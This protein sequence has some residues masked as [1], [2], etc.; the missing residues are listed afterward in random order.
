MKKY[1]LTICILVRN[2]ESDVARILSKLLPKKSSEIQV[3]IRDGGS[4]N[5]SKPYIS[6]PLR[7]NAIEYRHIQNEEIDQ[8]IIN[9]IRDAQ[10]EFVW[11]FG[12]DDLAEGALNEVLGLIKKFDK[13]NFIWA[14]FKLLDSNEKAVDLGESRFFIKKKKIFK[15]KKKRKT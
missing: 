10:G 8:K 1:L 6:E 4:N 14:N 2:Q 12:D 11:L 7:R 9:S 3:I 13:L 5:K 15:K